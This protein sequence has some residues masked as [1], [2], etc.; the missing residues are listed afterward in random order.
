VQENELI[1]RSNSP[2]LGEAVESLEMDYTGESM[3]ISFNARYLIDVL[4]VLEEET[5][6]L[7]LGDNFGPAILRPQEDKGYLC[8]IMPMRL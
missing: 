4:T 1:L 2:E 3:Q 6:V 8:V 7:E 5:V